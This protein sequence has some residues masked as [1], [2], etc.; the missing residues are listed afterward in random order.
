M[1]RFIVFFVKNYRPRSSP[2]ERGS[3]VTP[4]F[5]IRARSVAAHSC[6]RS[7]NSGRSVSAAAA[8]NPPVSSCPGTCRIN[9]MMSGINSLSSVADRM[10]EMLP[11][12][13]SPSALSRRAS[14][15]YWCPGAFARTHMCDTNPQLWCKTA[16]HACPAA[17]HWTGGGKFFR[18][19]PDPVSANQNNPTADSP[20]GIHGVRP[21]SYPEKLTRS[22]QQPSGSGA[23]GPFRINRA[24]PSTPSVSSRLSKTSTSPSVQ[25]ASECLGR[26][27]FCGPC[28]SRS[29]VFH[30]RWDRVKLMEIPALSASTGDS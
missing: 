14:V 12:L 29:R 2:T 15:S 23:L 7:R 20:A 25:R 18:F 17:F 6:T 28:T 10:P 4:P 9:A 24:K 8:T 1:E 11:T 16:A 30:L 13:P 19:R 26:A 22:S 27:G 3:C 5:L 21:N